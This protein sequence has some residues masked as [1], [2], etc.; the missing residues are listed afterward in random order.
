MESL[1]P[2]FSSPFFWG[3]ALGM[4]FLALSLWGHFKT[5]MELKRLR[6]NLSD[7]VEIE[8]QHL[9]EL[10]KEKEQLKEENENLRIKVKGSGENS[11]QT[12]E[13]ELEI[14]S[15]AEKSMYVTAP[16]FSAAWENAKNT[17]L[18]DIELE[19]EGKSI[20][21]KLFRKFFSASDKSG[22]EHLLSTSESSSSDSNNS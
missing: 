5:K 20:P 8:A 14:F 16:G 19:E 3:F 4:V 1:K 17:A 9:G 10:K 21:R 7:K 13:R 11:V 6:R 18:Q 15:R 2:I 22:T 12:L